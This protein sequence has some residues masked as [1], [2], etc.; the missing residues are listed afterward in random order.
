MGT[1]HTVAVHFRYDR[2][3]RRLVNEL[4]RRNPI[5]MTE[6]RISAMSARFGRDAFHLASAE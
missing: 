5:T 6:C 4:L 3:M 2:Y 1:V